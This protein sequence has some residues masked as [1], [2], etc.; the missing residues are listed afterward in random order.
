MGGTNGCMKLGSEVSVQKGNKP[1][2]LYYYNGIDAESLRVELSVRRLAL[3]DTNE[4][5]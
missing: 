2:C 1:K 4:Y 3:K 5:I